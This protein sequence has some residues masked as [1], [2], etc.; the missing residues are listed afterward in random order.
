MSILAPLYFL[1]ALAVGLPI[2]FHLIRRQPKGQVE[3]SSLIF[4]QP[5][6]PRL[7]RRSR[8]DNWP[9][10][11]LRAL[12]LMLLA[13]AFTRP[14]WRSTTLSDADVP[15]R[16]MVL[17]VD[18]SASMQR[19][20]LWQQSLDRAKDVIADLRREDQLAIVT[21][22]QSPTTLMSFEQS[23]RLTA[24]QV[25][26]TAEKLLRDAS[27]SWHAT[28]MGR[29]I[30]YA[31]DLAVSFEPEEDIKIGDEE[32]PATA[33]STAAHLVLIS[34]M[35]S[36]SQI[37][38]LQTYAWP[39]QLRLD[40]R[41]VAPKDRTNGSVTILASAAN[42]DTAGEDA[43]RV[44]VR[45]SNA[46]D[47]TESRFRLGWSGDSSAGE[48]AELPVQ[49]PPGESRV[50]RMPKPKPG[51]TSMVLRGDAHAFDNLHYVVSPK[52]SQYS[53]LHLG[54]ATQNPRD[55]LLYYLRRVPL[56][57]PYRVVNV[58]TSVPQD[59]G[60]LVAGINAK[61]VPLVV[62]EGAVPIEAT[63][64]LKSYVEQGGRLLVVLADEQRGSGLVASVN[65]I[66]GTQ[67]EVQ[68]ASVDDYVMFSKIDFRHS[69]FRLMSDPKFNDFTKVR[70]WSHR[71]LS[72]LAYETTEKSKTKWNL[73]ATFDD[74]DPAMVE[75]QIGSGQ[76]LV[77]AAGWQPAES[78]LALS[79]KFIPL[80]FSLFDGG[81]SDRSEGGFS[82]GQPIPYQPSDLATIVGPT[83]IEVPFQSSNDKV[84][85]QPGIYEYRKG[86]E[87]SRFAV[88]LGETESRTEPLGDDSL[89]RFGV[90]LGKTETT[91]QSLAN[92][93]QLRDVELESR[94]KLWQWLLLTALGLLGLETWWGAKLSRRKE[95]T[96]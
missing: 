17:V 79:T 29:A 10:L 63:K 1:G 93:R 18:T 31:A 12:V 64:G 61:R 21:F 35:Q 96:A 53:L 74:G 83:G 38:S 69:V 65:E 55:S 5:T 3:F 23:S 22:D 30:S 88:N 85:E 20:G 47:S 70:F 95:V 92:Q 51:V 32:S 57:N 36:G 42:S 84:I 87:T 11:L 13:A 46:K 62:M 66:A 80:V 27:P 39:D 14:Y 40:V 19:A 48:L 81:Q 94:Q 76:L 45:V 67:L 82:V 26:R 43:D 6:P 2:L 77:L 41:N 68:E 91:E 24:E 34:D 78:Q 7:T 89:E 75:T 73:I 28:E 49:V 25:R 52:P 44:R 59:A 90:L 86:D 50:V 33:T 72:N 4:L 15:G 37:E 58:E 9:L 56:D 71:K 8:L 54:D 60:E 16:R